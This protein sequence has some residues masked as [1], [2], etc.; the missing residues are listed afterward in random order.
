MIHN[1]QVL[2]VNYFFHLLGR[3]E[4]GRLESSKFVGELQMA[5]GREVR[6][7][8]KGK[9]LST[10]KQSLKASL[11]CPNPENFGVVQKPGCCRCRSMTYIFMA[12]LLRPSSR[13]QGWTDLPASFFWELNQDETLKQSCLNMLHESIF[14]PEIIL[15]AAKTLMYSILFCNLENTG[16]HHFEAAR[17]KPLLKSSMFC[18]NL[19]N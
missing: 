4:S 8:A 3:F 18:P 1:F 6:L 15:K 2:N 5:S 16:G 14:F 11:V 9:S 19:E 10:K 13:E 7:I 12:F 17:P